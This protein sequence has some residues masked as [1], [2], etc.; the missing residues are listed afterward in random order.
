MPLVKVKGTRQRG[1]NRDL[2]QSEM[3]INAWSDA[4]NIRILDG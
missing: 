4:K 3:P 1:L 2:S